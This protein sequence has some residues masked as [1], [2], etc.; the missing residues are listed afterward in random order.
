MYVQLLTY[1]PDPHALV[2]RILFEKRVFCYYFSVPVVGCLG[3]IEVTMIRSIMSRLTPPDKQGKVIHVFMY[4]ESEK[5][6]YLL[7][8]KN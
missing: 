3:I 5:F 4:M 1:V 6:M 7:I 8:N 2:L